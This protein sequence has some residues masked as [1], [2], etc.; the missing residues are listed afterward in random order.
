MTDSDNCQVLEHPDLVFETSQFC[1]DQVCI[2]VTRALAYRGLNFPAALQ[3]LFLWPAAEAVAEYAACRPEAFEAKKVIE[4]GAGV[5][6]LGLTI[7]SLQPSPAKVVVTDGSQDAVDLIG[8][9]I[10]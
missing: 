1:F 9:N 5:G 8:F 7:A 6:L 10:R 3:G 4:I 2:H